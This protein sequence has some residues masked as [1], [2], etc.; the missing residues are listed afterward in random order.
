MRIPNHAGTMF[1]LDDMYSSVFTMTLVTMVVM[2]AYTAALAAIVIIKRNRKVGHN[3]E[4][5]SIVIETSPQPPIY[6]IFCTKHLLHLIFHSC[7][8]KILSSG[9]S[10]SKMYSN[11]ISFPLNVLSSLLYLFHNFFYIPSPFSVLWTPWRKFKI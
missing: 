5:L 9:N 1:L 10:A 3:K 7:S 6:R 2:A 4:F 8:I 11:I